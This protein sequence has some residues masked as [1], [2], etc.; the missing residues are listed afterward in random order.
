MENTHDHD[1]F[2]ELKTLKMLIL[3]NKNSQNAKICIS[4]DINQRKWK[5]L[6]PKNLETQTFVW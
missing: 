4:N 3:S 5:M 2:L 6:I 1:C